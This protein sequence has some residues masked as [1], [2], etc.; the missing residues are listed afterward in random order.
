MDAS[1]APQVYDLALSCKLPN[2]FARVNNQWLGLFTR[3]FVALNSSQAIAIGRTIDRDVT[4]QYGSYVGSL[5][6]DFAS[7]AAI[8]VTG[9]YLCTFNR[10]TYCYNSIAQAWSEWQINTL[11]SQYDGAEST[12]TLYQ[13]S[14]MLAIGS[15]LDSFVATGDSARSVYRQRD[16][17]RSLSSS[18]TTALWYRDFSDA[19]YEFSGTLNA[20]KTSISVSAYDATVNPGEVPPYEWVPPAGAIADASND[21]A[22]FAWVAEVTQSAVTLTVQATVAPTVAGSATSPVTI[23]LNTELTDF[24]AGSVTVVAYAPIICRVQYAP[25]AAP[26]SN[27][28]FGDMLAT[29]ERAQP[30]WLIARF[31]NRQDYAN[32]SVAAVGQYRDTYG[33]SRALLMPSITATNNGI[34][35]DMAYHDAQRFFVPSERATDQMLGVEIWEGNAWQ[36]LAI[37]S[38]SPDRRPTENAKVVR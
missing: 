3:G 14:G 27:A 2:S 7:A 34:G 13:Q 15:Y 19:A 12:D 29:I 35:A 6:A 11:A 32:A 17:R 28:F 22:T 36:P 37:K 9:N 25:S 24:V 18:P 20:A 23:S 4:R 31:F 26:G 21:L 8:D 5:T 33:V 38:V 16:Y 1:F 30:G 10:K